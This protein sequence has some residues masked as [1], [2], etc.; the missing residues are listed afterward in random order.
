MRRSSDNVSPQP[1]APEL[2]AIV[3]LVARISAIYWHQDCFPKAF[4]H[5]RLHWLDAL[6]QFIADYSFERQ[7]AIAA[8]PR[9]ARAALQQAGNGLAEPMAPFERE[10][11]RLFGDLVKKAD[12]GLNPKL[13]PLNWELPGKTAATVFVGTLAE[14]EFNLL[15]WARALLANGRAEQATARLLEIRGVSWKLAA[16][17]LRDVAKHFNLDEQRCGPAWCF[18]PGDRWVQRIAAVWGRMLGRPVTKD[19]YDGS[20]QLFVELATAAGVRGGDVNAGAW[21]LSQLL[22]RDQR[23]VESSVSSLDRLEARLRETL[24]WNLACV[25]VIEPLLANRGNDGP[26]GPLHPAPL[27]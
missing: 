22:D 18:Q 9:S 10:A 5:A 7:G 3:R 15:L 6:I 1:Y 26:A 4:D 13:Q 19:D 14:W 11:W 2:L 16:F 8:Y 21:V 27:G 24:R 23:Q 17:Y 20:V 25:G 12:V